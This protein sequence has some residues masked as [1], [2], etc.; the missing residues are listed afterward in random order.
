MTI[1]GDEDSGKVGIFIGYGHSHDDYHIIRA[2]KGI[3]SYQ[4]CKGRLYSIISNQDYNNPI[5]KARLHGLGIQIIA[6][7]LPNNPT[8]KQRMLAILHVLKEL[9]IFSG[10]TEKD[11]PTD[12]LTMIK[13]HEDY[14]KDV[15]NKTVICIGLTA[16]NT[17]IEPQL[18]TKL[19]I[20]THGSGKPE[21]LRNNLDARIFS[22]VGGPAYIISRLVSSL[23]F[24]S[25]L[26]SK[27]AKDED[28]EFVYSELR[29]F[30]QEQYHQE[31]EQYL[32]LDFFES[33]EPE[34]ILDGYATWKSAILVEDNDMDNIK[35]QRTF[36]D[37]YIPYFNER[38]QIKNAQLVKNFI[39]DNNVVVPI[40]YFD[41]FHRDTVAYVISGRKELDTSVSTV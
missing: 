41:K 37:R 6:Y 29:K 30:E 28:G 14:Q 38:L 8:Q 40:I 11:I 31:Q 2:L 23:G 10:K 7:D 4:H 36:L 3:K 15:N 17:L 39:V 35:R 20:S 24:H 22:E 12:V 9:F 27:I 32:H 25:E 19:W 13:K 16:R 33:S 1:L 26:V 34:N 5:V 21:F 18:N